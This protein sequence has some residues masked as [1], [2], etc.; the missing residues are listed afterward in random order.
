MD[1]QAD[2]LMEEQW[3]DGIKYIKGCAVNAQ[4]DIV[5]ARLQEGTAAIGFDAFSGC[6]NLKTV[7]MP[8]TVFIIGICA[9]RGCQQ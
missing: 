6:D 9:F 4:K 7:D 2:E 3:I 1:E 8:D 5:H